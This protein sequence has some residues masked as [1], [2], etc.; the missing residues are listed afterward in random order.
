[1]F[2]VSIRAHWSAL[3]RENSTEHG[4]AAAERPAADVAFAALDIHV[5]R[6]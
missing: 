6:G 1:M 2:T 5:P 4:V 3:E